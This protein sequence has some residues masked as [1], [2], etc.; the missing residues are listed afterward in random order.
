MGRYSRVLAPPFLEF[1]GGNSRNEL[2]LALDVGCGPGAVTNV[3]ARRLGPDAVSAIDPSES[4]VASLRIALPGVD[5]RA[6]VAEE[7]PFVEGRFDLC[8]AQ[9]VVHFMADPV[10]GLAEMTRVT[11]SGGTVAACVWDHAEGGAPTSRFWRAVTALDPGCAGEPRRAGTWRGHL[12][13]L[14]ESTRLT[15]VEAGTLTVR[16]RYSS[17]D[18]WWEPYLLGIGRAG[19][20]VSRLNQS[21]RNALREKCREELPAGPFD[22]SAT[23]WAARGVVA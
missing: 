6:G 22:I 3:L 7:L 5:V 23:A 14:F 20:Y 4:F 19:E 21:G 18:E 16:V 11:R 1:A 2:R 15:R 12:V 8:V 17:F 10:A 13:Q 9:L